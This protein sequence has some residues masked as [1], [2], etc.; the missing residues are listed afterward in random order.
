[1]GARLAPAD[2]IIANCVGGTRGGGSRGG[3]VGLPE[4]ALAT[5]GAR[6]APV[7]DTMANC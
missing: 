7:A 6:P 3:D 2:E 4:R 1:M 5:M